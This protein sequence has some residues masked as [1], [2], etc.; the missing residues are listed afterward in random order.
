MERFG[1]GEVHEGFVDGE[2]LHLRRELFHHAANDAAFFDIFAHIAVD[3]LGLRAELQRLEHRHGAAH[4]IGAGDVAARRDD[5]ALAAADDDGVGLE[6]R[7]VALLDRGVEGVAI[8]M[9]DCERAEFGVLK[10]LLAAAGCA[11]VALRLQGAGAAED[12]R[13]RLMA[14]LRA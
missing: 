13:A 4:T 5:A 1:P 14:P 3:H 10:R 12:H 6:A 9:S 7:I 2:R 11:A 8:E